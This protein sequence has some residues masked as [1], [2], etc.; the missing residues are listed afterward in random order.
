MLINDNLDYPFGYLI[1][2]NDG[3]FVYSCLFV[4]KQAF[5]SDYKIVFEFS[6][7]IFVVHYAQQTCNVIAS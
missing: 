4:S 2:I 5:Y 1:F 3:L 6:S 7:L